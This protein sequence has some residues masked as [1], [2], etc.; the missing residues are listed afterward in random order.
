MR[1]TLCLLLL[2]ATAASAQNETSPEFKQRLR[3]AAGQTDTLVLSITEREDGRFV[4]DLPGEP[5][6]RAF[7]LH[8]TGAF[9]VRAPGVDRALVV[10]EPYGPR[11]TSIASEAPQLHTGLTGPNVAVLTPNAPIAEFRLRE[12]RAEDFTNFQ[13]GPIT[14]YH[15]VRVLACAD[16]QGE[17]CQTWVS[18][19]PA[20]GT[21]P[22]YLIIV[23]GERGR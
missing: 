7:V 14:T 1:L 15:R 8:D 12:V 21:G 22:L 19:A 13:E 6:T 10:V 4:Y 11:A 17:S 9:I 3:D 23:D 5:D 2:G 16:G 20:S 18:A